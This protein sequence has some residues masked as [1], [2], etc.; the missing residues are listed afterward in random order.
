MQL[1]SGVDF[2][3]ILRICLTDQGTADC[4]INW[5]L[6]L[7]PVCQSKNFKAGKSEL[8]LSL[9]TSITFFNNTLTHINHAAR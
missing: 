9:T 3:S 8:Q 1:Y 2:P 7:E 6:G 4:H 5:E